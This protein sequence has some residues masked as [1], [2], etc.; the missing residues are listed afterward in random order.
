MVWSRDWVEKKR[1]IHLH[2]ALLPTTGTD[3][4]EESDHG[5]HKITTTTPSSESVIV[6]A[7]VAMPSAKELS[8]HHM[9]GM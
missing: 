9:T 3:E 1:P 8:M 2:L 4:N 5:T 7:S 6:T